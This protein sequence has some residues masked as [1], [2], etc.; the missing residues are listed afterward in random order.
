MQLPRKQTNTDTSTVLIVQKHWS[1]RKHFAQSPELYQPRFFNVSCTRS[2][3]LCVITSAKHL[4]RYIMS[5]LESSFRFLTGNNTERQS[6]AGQVRYQFRSPFLYH[7]FENAGCI[8]KAWVQG[9]KFLLS[10]SQIN[11]RQER[12]II[13]SQF[14]LIRRQEQG[15]TK[16]QPKFN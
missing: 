14:A 12:Y 15:V 3:R 8:V 9:G 4:R 10:D 6:R 1:K 2:W 5:F 7:H 16:S 11:I 13:S